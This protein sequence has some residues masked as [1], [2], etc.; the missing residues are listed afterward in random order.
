MSTVFTTDN[1]GCA[2]SKDSCSGCPTYEMN[3]TPLTHYDL[4]RTMSLE[5]IAEWYWWMLRYVQGYTDSR[6][7]LVDWL[8]QNT[9]EYEKLR[10]YES[11]VEY[12]QYCEM[13]EPTYDPDTGAL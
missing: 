4:L 3:R 12:A 10:E 13:Y 6:V 11:S 5:E 1:S 9:N 7:A 2:C 8:K